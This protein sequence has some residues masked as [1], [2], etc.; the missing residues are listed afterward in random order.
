[1]YKDNFFNNDSN[2]DVFMY[3]LESFIMLGKNI[4]GL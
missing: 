2:A 3:Q 4:Y 1:M